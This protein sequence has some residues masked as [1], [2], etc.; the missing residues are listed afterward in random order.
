MENL[1]CPHCH[2]EVPYGAKVC[3]GCHAEVEYGMS[4]FIL[5]VAFLIGVILGGGIGQSFNLLGT[6]VYWVIV[7]LSIAGSIV[8]FRKI[9]VKRVVFKRI[10]KTK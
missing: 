10:Y 7:M 1:V 5:M 9:F 4:T 3:R 6:W 8:L 2:E